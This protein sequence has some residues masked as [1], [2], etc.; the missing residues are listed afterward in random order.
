[1]SDKP[2]ATQDDAR[3]ETKLQEAEAEAEDRPVEAALAKAAPAA[4]DGPELVRLLAA[5]GLILARVSQTDLLSI[6]AKRTAAAA[7][8]A[9]HPAYAPRVLPAVALD[10]VV[11]VD[12]AGDVH[13]LDATDRPLEIQKKVDAAEPLP[14]VEQAHALHAFIYRPTPEMAARTH[15][16]TRLRNLSDHMSGAQQTDPVAIAAA[17]RELVDIVHHQLPAAKPEHE[18]RRA[19]HALAGG[20][21][22]A[23]VT[24][25]D[26][27]CKLIE[28]RQPLP[29]EG[30]EEPAADP[31][32]VEIGE[33]QQ[34]LADGE[35]EECMAQLHDIV[36]KLEGSKPHV[37]APQ[38]DR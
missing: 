19:L 9:R 14:T 3:E 33:A 24:A 2:A 20:H 35:R 16:E 23:A 13:Q 27:A 34:A 38:P 25:M 31:A 8:V 21:T 12:A 5:Y 10:E 37:A 32:L 6:A 22:A 4:K 26:T 15:T 7:F 30:E 29:A 28:A 17:V 18:L 1:M 36:S 11:M